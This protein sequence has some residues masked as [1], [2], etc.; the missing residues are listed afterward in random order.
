MWQRWV[1][2]DNF[3]GL[4]LRLAL[5]AGVVYVL[6]RASAVFTAFVAAM[7]LAQIA[8]PFVK[9]LCRIPVPRVN[10]HTK[11][12][13]AVLIV[14]V[15]LGFLLYGVGYL[16]VQPFKAEW[17][18]FIANEEKNKAII[19]AKFAELT[20]WWKNDLNPYVRDYLEKQWKEWQDQQNNNPAGS[21]EMGAKVTEAL[22]HF[23]GETG[24]SI[25]HVV[26][27]ILLPVLAFYFIVEGHALRKELLLVFP[28]ERTRQVIA[29]LEEAG[30]VMRNYLKAQLLLAIIAGL[31]TG[32]L[33]YYLKVPYA[34]TLGL[35]AGITRAV[36]VVG[37]LLGGI[38]VVGVALLQTDR[39]WLWLVVLGVF[40]GLHLAES[41]IL[42]PQFLGRHLQL[43][44]V[45][46]ILALLLGGEFF[47]L[48][49]MFLAAPLAA[50]ARTLYVHYVVKPWEHS[51]SKEVTLL[52]RALRHVRPA[53]LANQAIPPTP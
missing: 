10:S 36:P 35:I 50:L 23:F 53:S 39:P 34:L 43:H 38:P 52:E 11:K 44:A 29:I 26:E 42:M 15:L 7:I 40:T 31:V 48:G 18:S 46:I 9:F 3:W 13:F 19:Q 28:R 33:L 49:G 1:Y 25:S 2:R 24:K 5:I 27:L 32:G 6:I 12:A 8:A 51:P 22:K 17:A 4:L 30:N 14:F 16:F 37:P 47:G 45:L 20:T 41:K 21:S